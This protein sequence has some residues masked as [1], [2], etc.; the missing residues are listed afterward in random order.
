MGKYNQIY[1]SIKIHIN[2][3]KW[4]NQCK[5]SMEHF[6]TFTLAS[7]NGSIPR[8]HFSGKLA[9][10]SNSKQV[11][12]AFTMAKAE[13]GAHFWWLTYPSEKWWSES[14]LGW[15]HSQYDGKNNPAM[16]QTTNQIRYLQVFA[17]CGC[18]SI[19]IRWYLQVYMINICVCIA[20]SCRL[21]TSQLSFTC[22]LKWGT[23]LNSTTDGSKE[24]LYIV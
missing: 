21:T 20:W 19:D 24:V 5:S 14:Q 17:S 2:L 9:V 18:I 7:P 15:W 1:K 6:R 16:F 11:K 23:Q 13:V 10:P 22:F 12:R 3:E 8:C 4:V